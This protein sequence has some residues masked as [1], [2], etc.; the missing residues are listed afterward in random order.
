MN[1]LIIILGI[2]LIIMIYYIISIVYAVPTV[3]KMVDLTKTTDVISPTSITDPYS[4]NYTIG[5]WIYVNQFTPQI[6][7]FL[8]FGDKTYYGP[9][10]L[11]S[12]RM[13]TQGNNLY[14]DVLVNKIGPTGA[15]T[16][17][18]TILPVLLNVANDSFPL[19][20]WVYVGVSISY[21]FVEA[22]LNG[23]FITAVNI[24]NNQTFGVNG[25]YQAPA[26]KDPNSG[27]TFTFGGLGSTMDDGSIR[28][29]GSPVMLANVSRWNSPM[30]SGDIYNIYLKG[31]GQESGMFGSSYHLNVN[32]TKDKNNYVLP[33]F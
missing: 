25:I 2:I 3:V 15:T 20:K 29:Y 30:T 13:D 17:T 31:N 23:K 26:P 18:P 16:S 8:M 12:L 27:A 32:V 6:G 10:S 5:V 4:V 9:Q 24:H 11:F 22:Y 19:Q 33:I 7:R 14:A 21:N 1:A 28:Q